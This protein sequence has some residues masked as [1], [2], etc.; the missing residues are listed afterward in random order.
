MLE[1]SY[2]HAVVRLIVWVE[3]F[4]NVVLL[5]VKTRFRKGK[6]DQRSARVGDASI[7]VQEELESR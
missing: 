4:E 7:Q 6:S 1:K 3:R 5:N 2:K